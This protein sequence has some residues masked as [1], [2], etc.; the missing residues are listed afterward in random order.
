[1]K[2]A[3]TTA[4]VFVAVISGYL[5][6]SSIDHRVQCAEELDRRPL[7]ARHC[8]S[9]DGGRASCACVYARQER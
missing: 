4:A 1:M 3:L 6:V 8:G 2:S 9:N 7:L 5:L